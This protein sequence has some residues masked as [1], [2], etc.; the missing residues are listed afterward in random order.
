MTLQTN[1][2]FQSLLNELK[3]MGSAANVTPT[4]SAEYHT[5]ITRFPANTLHA[6][7]L[8]GYCIGKGDSNSFCWWLE[9][10]L[11]PLLGRYMPGTSRGHLLYFLE[12]GSI[13]KHRRLKE[14]TDEAALAYTLRIH[15]CIAQAD[16]TQDLS[17]IDDDAQIYQRAD[18]SPRCTVGDGRKLRLLAAYHP[19]EMLPICSSD[20][21]AHFLA[22]FGYPASDI[23]ASRRPVAR[24]LLLLKYLQL[25]RRT[26]PDVTPVGF[27]RA[28]YSK[29]LGLAPLKEKEVP[30]DADPDDS[31]AEG[32]PTP[33]V[34]ARR[35]VALN[36]ILYGPPGT[37]KTYATI[38]AAMEIL[39]PA[40]W[41]AHRED[42]QREALTARF[43]EL[44]AL[45]RVQFVTFHQSF[46]YEDFVEGLRAYTDDATGQLRYEISD[47]VFKT[48]CDA[49]K[50][51]VVRQRSDDT[52][53]IAGRRV[54][55]MSLGNT[56]GEDSEIFDECIKDGVALLG[57]G[58][59]ISFNGCR[60]RK[61]VVSRFTAEGETIANPS[62]DYAVTSVTAFVTR[63]RVGDLLIISDGNFKFRAI[64][65]I[66]SDYQFRQHDVYEAAYC[67]AR[68]V[69]WLRQY[70]P[71]LPHTELMKSQFSQMTLYELRGHSIDL[72][73]L[74]TL[75]N[76]TEA[77]ARGDIARV[78]G[79]PRVLVIDEINRGNV[80]RIFGELITLIEPSKREGAAE[81]LEA[82]LP[83]SKKPFSVPDNVYLIGTMNTADRSLTGLDIALR[84]RFVFR[85]M[86]PAPT[87]LDG[88]HVE[89][90]DLAMLLVTLNLRIEALLD[91]DHCLGHAYF[92][93]LRNNP[94]LDK[95]AEIFQNQVLPLLQEYFF[96]DWQRI[97]WVLNDH[98]KPAAYQF[99]SKRP[100]DTAALFGV[101][102]NVSQ[103]SQIWAINEPAFWSVESYLGVI[104]HNIVA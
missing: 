81:T 37:G 101:D 47:G 32:D 97:Q 1:D 29:A 34:P 83:Y 76:T 5:F 91:R 52:L 96:E 54:W 35:Q 13:Y 28:L 20:H 72:E 6:L 7:N 78:E 45:Q 48:L 88:I 95:L 87:R 74:Q 79:E 18:V 58:G 80:S 22:A 99:I 2:N 50:A 69:R 15:S 86:L 55:K 67:Q 73:K 19:D 65:E 59:A 75:L 24:A 9:H 14:L 90:I 94:S 104:D 36:Q 84:R 62:T 11:R 102:V 12:D 64:G 66:T 49:A 103:R 85:E 33:T 100:L 41:Q 51:K 44:Q 27:M 70:E 23:P 4:S 10:G 39:D 93:P 38:D 40:F 17:W 26:Y 68:T 53:S 71:S 92:M 8:D 46:S 21:V 25:A 63:M 43:R 57:Y 82:I 61:D 60:N 42:G 56:L 3:S 31:A 77:R 30:D 89:G 16:V 98:R